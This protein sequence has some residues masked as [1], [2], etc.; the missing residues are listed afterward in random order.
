MPENTTTPGPLV[1]EIDRRLLAALDDD[2]RATVLALADRAGLARG[3]V[4]S[5]LERYQHDGTLRAH[6]TR[7]DPAALGRPLSAMVAAELDQHHIDEACDALARIPEVLEC[8]APAGETDLLCRVV[9][10]D[11][12]DLYRV[13]EEIR[14]CPGIVRTR[15]SVYL[16]RVIP[17][18]TRPLLEEGSPDAQPTRR[19][20]P[21]R[22][23]R[24]RS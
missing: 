15:T 18:R 8:F 11:P 14:L 13:S 23:Q 3:T 24:S 19:D 17:Y 4:Q 6:S 22:G 1:D 10:R 12:E 21:G 5:R 2:P 16:R 9:A 20:R 7:I